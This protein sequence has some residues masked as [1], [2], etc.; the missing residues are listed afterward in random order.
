MS[1]CIVRIRPDLPVGTISPRIYGHFAEHIGRCCYDGL[2]PKEA[3][4]P[5]QNGFRTDVSEAL[6]SLPTPLLRWPGG[7]YADHYHWKDGIGPPR[8]RPRR[9]GMSCGETVEEDNSLG[10][11]E[12][13]WFCAHIGAEPYLAGNV[14]SGTPQ[15]LCD[16]MEYCNTSLDTLWTRTRYQNGV[17]KPWHVRLWGVGNENWGCGGN[18]DAADYARE[19]RRYATMLRHVDQKAELVVC[20]WDQEQWNIDLANTLRNHSDLIDHFSIHR[21]W[22]GGE[23]DGF[24][25]EGY[26][27]LLKQAE[28][29]E[30]YI[31]RTHQVITDILG[32]ERK[33]GIALDEWGAWHKQASL[34]YD[35]AQRR[36]SYEQVNTLRDAIAA[37]IAFEGFHR[38]CNL[39]S[40]AN[41]AQIVNVLQ[42]PLQTHRSAMWRTPTY[43]VFHLYGRHQGAEAVTAE[44]ENSGSLPTGYAALSSTASQTSNKSL[45]VSLINRSYSEPVTLKLIGCE[46]ASFANAY[47]LT[48]S[49][50]DA[51]NSEHEP[52]LVHPVKLNMEG[53]PSAGLRFTLPPHSIASVWLNH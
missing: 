12:F 43:H 7:C 48:A 23:E 35:P 24:G 11:D 17:E 49:K 53:S 20:G 22:G 37:A 21:Y 4:I 6:H 19:Y 44:V 10:T 27:Q 5:Q 28:E 14:G 47:I 33:I 31:Q 40:M 29:T 3:D 41:I 52:D 13:L 36:G 9:L 51:A 39:L 8:D 2:R 32:K 50:P 34:G 26:Y 25:E 45:T 30:A 15:E 18:Y 46:S 1:D 38:Q 42:S 16:W